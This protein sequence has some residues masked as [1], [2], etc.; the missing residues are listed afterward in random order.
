[1]GPRIHP[2]ALVLVG[3]CAGNAI[4]YAGF[5]LDRPWAGTVAL[6]AYVVFLLVVKAAEWLI[7]A[8]TCR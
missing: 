3:L 6:A 2:R 8:S 4:T 1:M 7:L 5:A